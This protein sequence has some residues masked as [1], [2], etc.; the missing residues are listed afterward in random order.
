MTPLDGVTSIDPLPKVEACTS[1]A[2]CGDGLACFK[3]Y[4]TMDQDATIYD[5]GSACFDEMI[6][7]ACMEADH[8][9][10]GTMRFTNSDYDGIRE[11]SID[12]DCGDIKVKEGS[13]AATLT[14]ALTAALVYLQ[15]F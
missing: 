6:V 9:K 15:M 4:L 14:A 11:Y 1:T 8:N 3:Y 7:D 13:G 2:D 10:G 5:N 12:F